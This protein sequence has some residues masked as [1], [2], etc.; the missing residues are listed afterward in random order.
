M[1]GIDI[2]GLL[3]F[4]KILDKK[5][6]EKRCNRKLCMAKNQTPHAKLGNATRGDDKFR[7]RSSPSPQAEF[8]E[9]PRGIYPHKALGLYFLCPALQNASLQTLY[10]RGK[11]DLSPY[12]AFGVA[13]CHKS[14]NKR[15]ESVS[16]GIIFTNSPC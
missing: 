3:C 4:R 15:S 12:F 6:D 10:Y 11:L 9:I 14:K 8:G 5:S 1:F 7:T 2:W 13:K 16:P